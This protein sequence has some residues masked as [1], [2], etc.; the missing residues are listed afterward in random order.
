M[1]RIINAKMIL[2]LYATTHP[3]EQINIKLTDEQ[4]AFN[5]GY[6]YIN[7]GVCTFS[8][9]ALKDEYLELNTQELSALLFDKVRLYMSLMLE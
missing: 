1:A 4:L 5:T 3:D 8:K 9:K 6:Y 7:K 2:H